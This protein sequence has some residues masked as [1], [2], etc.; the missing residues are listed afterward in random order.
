MKMV[1]KTYRFRLFPMAEQEILLAKHFG[2]TR[3]VY[4]HFLNER[5]EQ[6]QADKKSD[7][8]YKQAAT[9]TKLKKEE[10]TKW[11]K[12]VN[13]QTLQF[14]LR[15]LDTAFLN[16]FRGNAQFPKF[17][18]RKH[19]NTFTIPQFGKLED[20][21]IIIPKFKDGIKVK[22]HREVKGKIG[23][24]SITKTP[25]GKYYVSIFTEQEVEE[26]PKTNK[27]VGIDLGL[28]DF[29]ITSDNKI[30][31]NNRYTKKY[32]K[33]LKKAQQHL[34]RKQKGS[35]GFEKQKLK[36]AKIHEKIASCR[37][38]TLH[39]VSKELV[40]S[41]DL[42]SIEDLNVKGMIKNHKLSKHIADA[43]WGNFVTLLQYKCDWYGKELVKVNR[44]YPSSKTCGDCNWIN[45]EL[46]LSDREWTCKSCGA[47]HDR[48]VN[49]SRNI[50]KEGLKII[51]G[52][53]LDNTDGDSNKASVK[54]HKS[55]K[56]EA[57]PIGSAVGG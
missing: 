49:A 19:K 22:L 50:L 18:S 14:A 56:S 40:E 21:K 6:Y 46:K 47:I 8:Y 9:L 44:F 4:N 43:S 31:K 25:T 32:A 27:Q 54:K 30:F 28:K 41:Y 17:K 29:V 37:L 23:K 34:S 55:V 36:V 16:F 20:G 45:Q 53:T 35:N 15:S 11:L 26:L 33:Q 5:K 13:S 42:I 51:S 12:E 57:Q 39:K 7:N 52:G 10:D 38:D 48:D 3:Y 24:M 2:C 1:N